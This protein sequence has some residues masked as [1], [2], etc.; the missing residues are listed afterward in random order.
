MKFLHI[1][2]SL[3]KGG[4]ERLVIDIVTEL[5]KQEN[6]SVKLVLFQNEIEYDIS[7]IRAHVIIIESFFHL[8]VLRKNTF[9]CTELNT[10]I[11]SFQP[12]II[13]THLF[14]AEVVPRLNKLDSCK[15]F[16]HAHWNTKEIK[17]PRFAQLFSRKG[18]IDF[19]VYLYMVN[20]YRNCKNNFIT[21]SEHT[22][23]FYK[24]NLPTFGNQIYF[25]RN[26]ILLHKFMLISNRHIEDS[27][28]MRIVTVGSLND[29]KNQSFQIDIAIELKKLGVDFYLSI[30]GDG[31]IKE[32]LQDKINQFALND[33]VCLVGNTNHVEQ[34]LMENDV[35][36]HTAKYE[37]FGLVLVEALASGLPVVAYSAGGSDEIIKNGF[38][39]YKITNLD[40]VVFAE[41]IINLYLDKSI[42]S[43]LS[44]NAVATSQSYDIKPYVEQLLKLYKNHE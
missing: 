38:N 41:E 26:A 6:V 35:F 37:P 19:Y 31:P 22:T 7:E 3:R 21:I 42:Y 36:L 23:T 10:F 40:P 29:R 39:G 20:I 27:P 12:N 43:R 2:P 30:I 14:D 18:L 32:I 11:A 4:A 17:R 44:K 15:Y 1:I 16:S 25:L 28:K 33:S 8:V 34:H 13:H 24:K 9:Q 5:L